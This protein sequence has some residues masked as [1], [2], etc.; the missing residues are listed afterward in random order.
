MLRVVWI[1]FNTYYFHWQRS[2]VLYY[3]V[4]L[5]KKNFCYQTHCTF[6]SNQLLKYSFRYNEIF[7]NYY[8]G[9]KDSNFYNFLKSFVFFCPFC[10][11]AF[12]FSS[13]W[14]WFRVYPKWY[15]ITSIDRFRVKHGMTIWGRKFTNSN[16]TKMDFY[17]TLFSI[18]IYPSPELRPPSPTRGEG[19]KSPIWEF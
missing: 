19:N 17:W 5:L 13:P 10:L 6:F 3:T 16:W 18:F 15:F 8:K 4:K 1:I 14:T 9:S 7:I 11:E 2:L 12:S